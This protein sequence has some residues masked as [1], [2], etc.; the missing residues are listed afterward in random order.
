[1]E[2]SEIKIG[3]SVTS[4]RS[5][6][7]NSGQLISRLEKLG[8]ESFVPDSS[9]KHLALR[10]ALWSSFGSSRV[11]VLPGTC[12][13]A[14]INAVATSDSWSGESKLV[15]KFDLSG[16]SFSQEHPKRE[17]IEAAFEREQQ[18]IPADELSKM[19]GHL[20]M[21]LGG[22]PSVSGGGGLY[23]IPLDSVPVWKQIAKAV[24]DCSNTGNSKV[25]M[26]TTVMDGDSLNAVIASLETNV[27]KEL[28]DIEK[29]IATKDLGKLALNNR[30]KTSDDLR[31][32]IRSYE[33]MYG[34]AMAKLHDAVERT[35]KTSI[36]AAL[37]AL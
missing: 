12:N 16:L 34:S 6:S 1:M 19:L 32:R 23:W 30:L 24:E 33:G 20:A 3:G 10:N 5:S 11:K 37:Q 2:Q 27:E 35:K 26:F 21:R 4:W 8:F 13:F 14:A 7:T 31:T 29:D 36:V 17:D 15:V 25:A 28:A 18:N 22:I 9:S